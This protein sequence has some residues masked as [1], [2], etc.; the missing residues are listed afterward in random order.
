MISRRQLIKATLSTSS[1]T[2]LPALH[3]QPSTNWPEKPV[4]IVLPF[5]VGGAA[6]VL[7]RVLAERLQSRF[8]QTFLVENITGAGGNLGMQ[9]VKRAAPDGY[10]MGC[11]TVGTLSIN[12]FLFSKLP[13]DPVKDFSYVSTFF[14]NCNM[15]IVAAQHPAKTAQEFVAWARKQA[16]GVKYG[17]PGVGTTPHLSA[18]LFR[19]RADIQTLHIPFRGV[20]Q[21][22]PALLSGDTDFAIENIA[23]YISMLKAGKVRALAVTSSERWPTLPE[24]PTMTEAGIKDLIITSW[25]AFVMPRGTPPAI[26]EKVSTALQTIAADPGL[27]QRFLDIG[28]RAI[29][30]SP[31]QLVQFAEQE[32]VKWKEIVALSGVPME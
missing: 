6:D 1:F 12:Q 19:V 16:Q 21:S 3:A 27:R 2:V 10:T 15:L 11:A 30:S 24:V 26:T 28:A 20:A 4:R 32:R 7:V 8:G 23:S 31:A 17:S 14:D 18:E 9:A 5:G 25:G 22:I 13:Y 29:S